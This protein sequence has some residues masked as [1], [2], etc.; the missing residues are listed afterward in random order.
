MLLSDISINKYI[1]EINTQ[2][3]TPFVWSNPLINLVVEMLYKTYTKQVCR[4]WGSFKIGKY[5]FIHHQTY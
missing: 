5:I 4:T 1:I 3:C 2:I